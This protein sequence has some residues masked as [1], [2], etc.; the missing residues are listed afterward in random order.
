MKK[1]ILALFVLIS[2]LSYGQTSSGDL[3]HVVIFKF[4]ET[5]SKASVDSVVKSFMG[6]AKKIPVIKS[7][8]WGLNDSPENFHQGFTH[9]FVI[10]F[11][12]KKDRD[13]VYQKHP[14]HMEFQKVL[15]PHM[16]KVFVVDYKA[17]N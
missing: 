11:S 17:E 5:S 2:G 9:C 1:I 10:T 15:G 16:E 7:M 13:E 4:K 12:N 3:R 8:E 6:L 14:A